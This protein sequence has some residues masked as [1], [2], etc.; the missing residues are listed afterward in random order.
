LAAIFAKLQFDF[1]QSKRA[2]QEQ[3]C[4]LQAKIGDHW[5]SMRKEDCSK[6][7]SQKYKQNR[8]MPFAKIKVRR[9]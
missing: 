3:S 7:L 1:P 2:L 4:R 5:L 9:T 8:I 6:D